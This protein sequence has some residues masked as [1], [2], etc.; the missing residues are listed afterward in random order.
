[1]HTWSTHGAMLTAL[2]VLLSSQII[3]IIWLSRVAAHARRLSRL[4]SRATSRA[5][6][7]EKWDSRLT[8]L[9]AEVVS[10]SSSFEKVT[11]QLM[12]LN[13]REGM[14]ELRAREDGPGTPPPLG[15]PKGE[16]RKFYGLQGLSGPEV[17]RRQM[18][19]IPSQE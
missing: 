11:R 15:T 16:L 18:S 6:A 13:S 10:L 5:L 3:T 2:V 8:D 14:R 19:L 9:S 12:R 17:A 4:V 1:M 7:P